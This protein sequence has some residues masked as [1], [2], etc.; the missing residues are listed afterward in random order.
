[1]PISSSEIVISLANVSKDLVSDEHILKATELLENAFVQNQDAQIVLDF[2]DVEL[3]SSRF[4]F[5][6]FVALK[7]L[8]GPEYVQRTRIRIGTNENRAVLESTI[9]GAAKAAK[10][11]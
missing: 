9:R 6:L 2:K 7:R 1:M 8:L 4:A 5:G 10:S 11:D 3:A